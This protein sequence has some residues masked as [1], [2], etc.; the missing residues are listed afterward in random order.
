MVFIAS[1]A[2][3]VPMSFWSRGLL[4]VAA[5]PTCGSGLKLREQ[6]GLLLTTKPNRPPVPVLINKTGPLGLSGYPGTVGEPAS[7]IHQTTPQT[8]RSALWTTH[9]T[10][11]LQF[12]YSQM[13]ECHK[14]L[15]NGRG[16]RVAR[17]R[18][19]RSAVAHVV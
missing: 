2:R 13:V 19:G 5:V 7:S 15:R 6:V 3:N 14:S 4:A 9:L 8:T 1:T 18:S 12:N 11:A 17:E 16:Q 10:A